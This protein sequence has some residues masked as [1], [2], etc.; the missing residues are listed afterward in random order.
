MM[1][2]ANLVSSTAAHPI[3]QARN[4]LLAPKP[5]RQL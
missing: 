5:T 4:L 2:I 3:Q 1:A